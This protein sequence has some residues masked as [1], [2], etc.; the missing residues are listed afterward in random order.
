MPR[1]RKSLR[2]LIVIVQLAL[3]TR[4][5]AAEPSMLTLYEAQERALR[6]HPRISVAELR[7]LAAKEVTRQARSGFFPTLTA[8][9]TAA[10]GA[11][12]NTRLAAGALNNPSIFQRN[13]EGLVL[14]QI[15]TDFGRTANLT[16]SANF[17]ARADEENAEATRAQ[18]MLQVS[19]AYFSALQA[20]AVLRVA[21]QT[22]ATR[23]LLLDQISVLASN[24]IRSD[25]DV[26]LARVSFEEGRLMRSKASNDVDAAF[27]SLST[28]LGERK[29]QSFQ[30]VE[31]PLPA[32]FPTNADAM[33]VEAMGRRPDLIRLRFEH[34][35]AIKFARAEK[36]L[37][38]PVISAVASAGVVPLHDSHF[39]NNYAAA[40]VNLS[41][42]LFNGFLFSGRQKEAELKAA[43][44]EQSLRDEENKTIR[45]VRIA[46]L[47]ANNALDRL[48][49]SEQLLVE[50]RRTYA[51]AEARYKVRSSSFVELSQAELNA[52]SAEIGNASARYETQLQE[53][54]L[55]FQTGAIV[56]D[57]GK[58]KR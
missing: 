33:I 43:A 19:A 34:D 13:A 29:P 54:I 38:Y 16:A 4:L 18:I 40:G 42:P 14:S 15:I 48:R 51:L 10:S 25:L 24:K 49:I 45:D 23:Q 50:A 31:E 5:S 12:D 8:N 28:L 37:H 21:R 6:N 9:V 20:Q 46:L 11:D 57:S 41:L 2:L 35:A 7:A 30:I 52:V 26:G 17:R 36:A 1:S 56:P 58:L 44:A 3:A 27:I 47:D 39:E 32:A 53:Q 22:V 55:R